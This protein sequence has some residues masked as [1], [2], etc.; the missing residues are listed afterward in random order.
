MSILR[1]QRKS[2]Y[3]VDFRVRFEPSQNDLAVFES[4]KAYRERL[5]I[6]EPPDRDTW[7]RI[8][9]SISPI[10]GVWHSGEK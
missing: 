4:Y 6:F 3:A 8:N 9:N 7:L 5:G 2:R 1:P 10:F